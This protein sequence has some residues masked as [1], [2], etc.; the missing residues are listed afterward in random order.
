MPFK[1]INLIDLPDESL[2]KTYESEGTFTDCYTVNLNTAVT[3]EQYVQNFYST[4]LFKVERFLL[5]VF[6]GYPSSDETAKLLANGETDKFAAWTVEGRSKNQILLCDVS[7]RT[8]SW[9]M[10]DRRT[11][12]GSQLYFGSA[13]VRKLNPKSGK[14]EMGRLFKI[15]LG[16]HKLYSKLL[17]NSAK[18]KL[19]K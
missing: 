10:L 14:T 12:T 1:N 17:L 7:G 4:P 3:F 18:E 9:L 16:F 6:A 11:D 15:L 8:R 2:L 5:K 19:T 13:V